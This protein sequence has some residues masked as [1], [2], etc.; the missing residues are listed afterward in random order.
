MKTLRFLII[1]CLVGF[2]FSCNE[3]GGTIIVENNYDVQKYVTVLS[4]V[5]GNFVITYKDKYGPKIVFANEV[6][7]FDVK[8]NTD[9]TIFWGDTTQLSSDN[10]RNVDVSN[11]NTVT[12][13][14]P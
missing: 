14:I 9:Y 8:S 1:I 6:I 11:G 5:S 3:Y 10:K 12:V 2:L 4:D 13:K 7:S